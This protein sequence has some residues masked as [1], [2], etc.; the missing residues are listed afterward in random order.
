MQVTSVVCCVSNPNPNHNHNHNPNQMM[1]GEAKGMQI[2]PTEPIMAAIR[3][4][5]DIINLFLYLLQAMS[6]G[7]RD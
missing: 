5:M 1:G 2:R 7:Q 3:L 6:S 4:Y